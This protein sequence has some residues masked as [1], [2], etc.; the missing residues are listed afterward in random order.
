MQ[1]DVRGAGPALVMLHGWAMHGAV[2]APLSERLERHFTLHLVD[3]PGHGRS[4]DSALPLTLD[5]VAREV[6]ARTP[7]A[8]W[9]GWS[10]G[11]L[12]ALHAAQVLPGS[13]QALLMLCASPRFV[14]GDDWPQG[15]DASVFGTFASELARDYRGTI[16]RFLL[17][18]AQGSDHA[19]EEIRL[20]REL[21]FACGEPAPEQLRAGL[22]L[23][24]DSDLRAGL[25]Q[26]AMPSLWLAGRRDR[27]VA[28]AAMQWAA[29][30]SPGGRFLQIDSGGHAPFL[31]HA[32]QVARAIVEFQPALPA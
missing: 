27:L 25:A 20:L 13:V 22:G 29:S 2:F 10:L 26:L 24:Q 18:E 14:R 12:V 31:T 8:P 5:A 28:P 23:L 16:D 11:G 9:L 32:D 17:L 21:V 7:P 4:R 15:M 30:A 6:A 19:R 3:L 1:I